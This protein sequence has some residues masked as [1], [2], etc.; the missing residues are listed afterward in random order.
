MKH[1]EAAIAAIVS[2]IAFDRDQEKAD[3]HCLLLVNREP[4]FDDIPF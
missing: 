1:L 3:L 4:A 2:T